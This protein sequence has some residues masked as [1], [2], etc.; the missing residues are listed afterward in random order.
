MFWSVLTV[1]GGLLFTLAG[2]VITFIVAPLMKPDYDAPSWLNMGKYVKTPEDRARY[3]EV[4][5]KVHWYRLGVGLLVSGT[6]L[7][8]IGTARQVAR[9]A[10]KG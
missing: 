9:L 1:A 7:Q 3:N 4:M 10:C 6:A 8:L 5:R 2:M